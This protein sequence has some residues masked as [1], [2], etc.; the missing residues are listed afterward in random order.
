[1][2]V[3]KRY[4][5]SWVFT[6]VQSVHIRIKSSLTPPLKNRGSAYAAVAYLLVIVLITPKCI[7]S[8]VSQS[9]YARFL[10][11]RIDTLWKICSTTSRSTVV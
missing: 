10:T 2:F 11:K 4:L 7:K 8:T 3:K 5:S 6:A 9:S 1:V